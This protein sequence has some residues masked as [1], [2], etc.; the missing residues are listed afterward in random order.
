MTWRSR[1]GLG[2]APV[3]LRLAL[4]SVFLYA[5][6]GKLF[7]SMPVSG[8][9]AGRL[10]SLGLA[11]PPAPKG[12]EPPPRDIVVP[13]EPSVRVPEAEPVAP[14]P[15]TEPPAE[16]DSPADPPTDP[17]LNARRS[18]AQIDSPA[19]QQPTPI[20]PEPVAPAKSQAP[21][22]TVELPV[23][24]EEAASTPFVGE[25][26]VSR[27]L[28]L[29]LAMDGAHDR[30]QWPA[31]LS[32]AGALDGLAWAAA[33]IEF[34]GGWLMLL[35]LMTRIWA[36][37]LAGVMAGALWL[38]QL[39][40]AMA[41]G[42]AFLWVLPAWEMDDPARWTSAWQSMFFQFTLMCAALA[43]TLL[44]AGWPSLDALLFGSHRHD[45]VAASHKVRSGSRPPATMAK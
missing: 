27:R 26:V 20:T 28:G 34:I 33:L 9:P 45:S 12:V 5:G 24:P 7:Y 14:E 22:V 32:T 42:T 8:D 37:G 35:G 38:T 11:E 3:C 15:Q 43:V 13:T 44:G 31:A 29:V 39:G 40:P 6:A 25:I 36:L 4:A 16:E 1:V 10:V 21:P 18:V 19:A 2:L 30:G 41:S 17:E 23:E